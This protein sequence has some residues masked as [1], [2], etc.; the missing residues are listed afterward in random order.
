MAMAIVMTMLSVWRERTENRVSTLS[1]ERS[2]WGPK[3][4]SNKGAATALIVHRREFSHWETDRLRSIK[5][6]LGTG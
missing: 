5:S 1:S 6:G 2:M 3:E 4:N